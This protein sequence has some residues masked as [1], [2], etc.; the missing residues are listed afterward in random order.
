M[1]KGTVGPMLELRSLFE[2]YQLKR[3][4]SIRPDD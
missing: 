4:K 1:S 2:E 3:A